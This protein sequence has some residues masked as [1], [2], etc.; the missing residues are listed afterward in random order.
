MYDAIIGDSIAPGILTIRILRSSIIALIEA[1]IKAI[2]EHEKRGLCFCSFVLSSCA[3]WV[4][5]PWMGE[6]RSTAPLPAPGVCSNI[7]KDLFK[8]ALDAGRGTLTCDRL[9]TALWNTLSHK[10]QLAWLQGHPGWRHL[11]VAT[12]DSQLLQMI[13]FSSLRVFT[14]VRE[15]CWIGSSVSTATIDTK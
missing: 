12:S 2:I 10:P 4:L 13:T 14:V 9:A 8:Q 7:L 15:G 6:I 11:W 1:S 3:A 5:I